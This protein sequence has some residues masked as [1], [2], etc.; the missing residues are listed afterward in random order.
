MRLPADTT[1]LARV[2]WVAQWMTVSMPSKR[3]VDAVAAEEVT[4]RPVDAGIADARL[5]AQR[6]DLVAGFG[7][8]TD[9]SVPERAGRAGDENIAPHGCVADVGVRCPGDAAMPKRFQPRAR[10]STNRI[11]IACLQGPGNQPFRAE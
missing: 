7:G 4:L 3:G 9:H 11:P 5:S 2:P 6:A 10:W 1:S 8:F